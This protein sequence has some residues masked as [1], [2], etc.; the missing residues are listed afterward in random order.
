MALVGRGGGVAKGSPSLAEHGLVPVALPRAFHCQLEVVVV[1][2]EVMMKNE[3]KKRKKKKKK[4][5]M[6]PC[7]SISP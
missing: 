1:Q 6:K 5:G 3:F 7:V 4:L 2:K